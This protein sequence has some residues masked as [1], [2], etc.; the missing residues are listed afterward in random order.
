MNL[1]RRIVGVLLLAVA[2]TAI[3]MFAFKN[4]E[5]ADA[6]EMA[7]TSAPQ[8][9]PVAITK[10]APEDVQLWKNYSGHVVAVDHAEIRPQVSGRIMEIR[11]EDGQHVEEGDVLIVIDPKPYK[12]A[13]SQAEAALQAAGTQAAL[14]EK[15][16]QRA[17][18]L[19]ETN[20]IAQGLMDERL[21]NRQTAAA[22]VKGAQAAVESAKVDLDY[23]YVKAPISG[24]ISRAEI[25]VGNLVQPG[26]NAPLLTS[27]VAEDT[28]YVDFEVDERFYINSISKQNEQAAGEIPVR[29]ALADGDVTYNG[30]IHSFDNRID[31]ASGT[32]RA[33]AI[34][35]NDSKMLLPGMSVTVFMGDASAEKKIML[36]ERAIGTDQNRKFVYTVN[37]EGLSEYREV[38]IGDSLDGRRVILAGLETGDQ[39]ITDGVARIRPGM[40][41]TASNNDVSE[42]PP[43]ELVE[44]P[45]DVEPAAE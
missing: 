38:K 39:V 10:V 29:V 1:T 35:D 33:R 4:S 28:V 40:P 31:P 22:Q 45:T 32:I 20:A 7:E 15:E 9:M 12:A 30:T 6:S 44:S 41:V 36:S 21:N 19:I 8:A 24:K 2:I 27:I 26:S 25:T 34:F 16:Y 42:T 3:T 5:Q 13:L 23:A 14:A 11:F 18:S 37:P 17:K 43:S